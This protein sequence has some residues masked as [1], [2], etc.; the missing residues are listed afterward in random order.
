MKGIS[1]QDILDEIDVN[2]FGGARRKFLPGLLISFVEFLRHLDA[3]GGKFKSLD[4][5]YKVYPRQMKTSRGGRANT[6]IV[7]FKG[8]NYSI[9]T[10]YDRIMDWFR[11]D[12]K[13]FDYPS[14][15]PHSTQAW[16]DYV[17]WINALLGFTEHELDDLVEKAKAYVLEKLPSQDIDPLKVKRE[18]ARFLRFLESFE[19]GV[20]NEKT[21]AA[22]QGTVFGYI[23]A[24]APHLQVEVGKVRTGSKREKRVGDIDARDGDALVMAAEVKQYVVEDADLNTL[25]EF[26]ILI[27]RHRA[28]GLV[29]ALDFGNGIREKL[30]TEGLQPVS[31]ADLI[32]RVRLWDPLKQKIAINALLYYIGFREQNSALHAR[33]KTFLDA[34]DAVETVEVEIEPIEPDSEA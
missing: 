9:R 21:G 31:R 10:E 20:S 5:L 4:E 26:A 14:S 28:L 25:S 30:L 16:E 11:S 19:M 18:P 8:R 27:G 33:I 3:T 22:Y 29:V 7:V 15:A 6:L 23:R 1:P 34:V 32:E 24:D 2:F 17:R 13:R 12:Q